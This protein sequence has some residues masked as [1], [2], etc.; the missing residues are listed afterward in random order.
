MPVQRDT[1]K[2][3]HRDLPGRTRP[4]RHRPA[5]EPPYPLHNSTPGF[6]ADGIHRDPTNGQRS[7][8]HVSRHCRDPSRHRAGR[9]RRH[10]R[11]DRVQ[12]R[13]HAPERR[14]RPPRPTAPR[15]SR[16]SSSLRMPTAGTASAGAGVG[17]SSGSS[18]S[19]SSCSSCSPSLRA[20]FWGG[21]GRW[22]RGW[23]PGYGPGGWYGDTGPNGHGRGGW[24]SHA[25]E[26]FDDW[27]QRAHGGSG[28][29]TTD[30]PGSGSSEPPAPPTQTGMA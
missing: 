27:H 7:P 22:G 28:S 14:S 29:S 21:R 16:R 2:T 23:G 20:I 3:G 11:H 25:H 15:P 19:C 9:R 13:R 8:L 5:T 4:E 30:E 1:V 26:T 12:R 24:E 6:E 10:R 17:G 18:S